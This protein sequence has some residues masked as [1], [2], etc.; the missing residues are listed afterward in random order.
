[1]IGRPEK[2][3]AAPY[4]FRYIDRVPE[5]DVLEVLEKQEREIPAFL[6]GI[7]EERSRH[8]Y[9]PG[10]WSIRQVWN[11]V[12]DTERVFVFRAFWFARGLEGALPGFEQD[13]AAGTAQAD[14]V[15]WERHIEEF[16]VVRRATLTFFGNLPA[17]AWGRGGI[18]SDFPFTVRAC[19]YVAAGHVVHHAAILRERYS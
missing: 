19:A 3:E 1:V 4:F 10:K 14:E 17:E 2:S 12:N 8:R 16:R 15:F 6:G 13:A 5:Q 9:A 18:A 11:H 7:S